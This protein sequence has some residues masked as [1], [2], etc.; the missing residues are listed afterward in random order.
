MDIKD[1]LQALAKPFAGDS[2]KISGSARDVPTM[3]SKSSVQSG[4]ERGRNEK[5]SSKYTT[6]LYG[7]V[8]QTSL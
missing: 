1:R 4:K 8:K 2:K 3:K 5:L 7:L 6:P